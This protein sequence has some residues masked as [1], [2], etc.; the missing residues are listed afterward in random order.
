MFTRIA[1]RM[2]FARFV[3]HGHQLAA[4]P[5]FSI[6]S[7]F[8]LAIALLT[9]CG[10]G[11][12]SSGARAAEPGNSVA[13]EQAADAETDDAP[14]ADLAISVGELEQV[15]AEWPTELAAMQE[16]GKGWQPGADLVQVDVGC[17]MDVFFG[18]ENDGS[19]EWDGIFYAPGN[20]N[21]HSADGSTYM[22]LSEAP[23]DPSLVS[24]AEL[25]DWLVAAG[26][27]EGT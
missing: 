7:L 17:S 18:G 8:V 23:L 15:D 24:F 25:H 9:A 20:G 11:D 5:G 21:W 10:G 27:D 16:A 3:I 14:C 1:H 13:Q 12:G 26:Y 4:G 6:A 22:V 19:I 2:T